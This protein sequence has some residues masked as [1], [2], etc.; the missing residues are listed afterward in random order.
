MSRRSALRLALQR[1]SAAPAAWLLDSPV[2]TDL[3]PPVHRFLLGAR[4]HHALGRND[5]ALVLKDLRTLAVRYGRDEL[6]HRLLF[7]RG[8]RPKDPASQR[9]LF[10]AVADEPAFAE[11]HRNYA[12]ISLAYRTL[13]DGDA[14]QAR[15]LIPR[16]EA[17]AKALHN[18]PLTLFCRERN[19]VNRAKL[20]I[21]AWATLMHLHLLVGDRAGVSGIGRRA[22]ALAE[23]IDYAQLPADVAYRLTTN[24]ARVLGIGWLDAWRR[25][26]HPAR[27]RAMGALEALQRQS[28]NERHGDSGAQEN[29]RT[30]VRELIEALQPL[31][32][33]P[34]PGP[35][36]HHLQPLAPE[37]ILN[38]STPRMVEQLGAFLGPAAG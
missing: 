17:M 38:V 15:T 32:T 16:I 35:A 7:R 13:K 10:W 25:G 27:L 36:S 31:A 1:R 30:F 9:R 5:D 4:I 29:H 23:R 6:V 3:P 33:Q 34:P 37:R 22:I 11:R 18:D 20:L 14:D 8:F 26:D 19:R 12:L 24:F 2:G 21:S 28:V